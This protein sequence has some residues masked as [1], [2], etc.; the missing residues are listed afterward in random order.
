MHKGLGTSTSEE[1]REYFSD[2]GLHK[3]SFSYS[4]RDD[5]LALTMAFGKAG[6]KYF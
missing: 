5:D 6:A 2:L 3:K 1:A 4:G